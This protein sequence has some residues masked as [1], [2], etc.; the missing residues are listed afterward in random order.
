MQPEFVKEKKLTLLRDA[1]HILH[2]KVLTL[3][4]AM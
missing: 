2:E 4:F 1:V 3:H